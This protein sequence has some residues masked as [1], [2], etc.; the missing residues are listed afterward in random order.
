VA[1][2]VAASVAA[3][4]IGSAPDQGNIAAAVDRIIAERAA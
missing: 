4:L 2:D 3:K 1:A